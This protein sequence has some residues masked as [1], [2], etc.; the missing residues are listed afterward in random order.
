MKEAREVFGKIAAN[1]KNYYDKD[2]A[3]MPDISMFELS[4]RET[5][6]V[7]K[8]VTFADHLAKTLTCA[9]DSYDKDP[10]RQKDTT[11]QANFSVKTR[12]PNAALALDIMNNAKVVDD[13]DGDEEDDTDAEEEPELVDTDDDNEEEDSQSQCHNTDAEEESDE[14]PVCH[15]D[16][17][18]TGG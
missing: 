4:Y 13:D 18:E 5:L 17:N 14:E 16:F 15:V 10:V 9:T 8:N 11:P 2:N 1:K 12:P 6:Y 3:D 7:I